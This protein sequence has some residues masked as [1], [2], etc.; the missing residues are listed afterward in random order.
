MMQTVNSSQ[1][2]SW[3]SRVMQNVNILSGLAAVMAG[4]VLLPMLA[5]VWIALFPSDNIWPHLLATT[6]PVYMKNTLILMIGVGICTIL[7]GTGCAWMSVRFSFWGLSWLRWAMLMPLAIPG[8][9]GAYALVDLLEYAGPVQTGMR[10][11]MGYQ[12]AQDYWF[13]EIRSM[14]AA[15]IILSAS[16]YPYV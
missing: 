2:R 10:A 5:V 7:V 14:G 9:L 13:P 8:Y 11:V 6:F 15:I 12:S 4:L 3:L 16:L 1:R